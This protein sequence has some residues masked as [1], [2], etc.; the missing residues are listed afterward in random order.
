MNLR[1]TTPRKIYKRLS[2][3][4]KV[5][6][7]TITSSC[8]VAVFT[9]FI[10]LTYQY[11]VIDE[12]KEEN[13]RIMHTQYVDNILPILLQRRCIENYSFILSNRKNKIG[14]TIERIKKANNQNNILISEVTNDYNLLAQINEFADSI[15]SY[16]KQ[17]HGVIDIP[18]YYLYDN[19]RDSIS[20]K[21]DD[22]ELQIK[23][24]EILDFIMKN[25]SLSKDVMNAQLEDII[26][27]PAALDAK[28]NKIV[29]DCYNASFADNTVSKLKLAISMFDNIIQIND[30][31]E[32][33]SMPPFNKTPIN[34]GRNNVIIVGF[35]LCLIGGL[36]WIII[37]NIT[38][39]NKYLSSNPYSSS[40]SVNNSDIINEIISLYNN[41]EIIND[42][43][44]VTDPLIIYKR[45]YHQWNDMR[46]ELNRLR[47]KNDSLSS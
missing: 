43:E 12:S 16:S 29:D 32:K 19:L 15:Y 42:D 14:N 9:F 30:I 38:F 27:V 44:Y 39:R 25:S 40:D 11:L 47:N 4:N 20:I 33:E 35:L 13:R 23:G 22:L 37:I 8:F 1:L 6:F 34:Q 3:N 7:W 24:Y 17:F 36:C 10:G 45:L 5:H 28:L 26:A 41:N 46:I 18:K 2:N 31:F 21:Q